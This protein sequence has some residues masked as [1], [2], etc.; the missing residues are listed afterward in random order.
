[1]T[2]RPQTDAFKCYVIDVKDPARKFALFW[3][4]EPQIFPE[5]TTLYASVDESKHLHEL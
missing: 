3:G 5:S 4:V 2:I 1:V